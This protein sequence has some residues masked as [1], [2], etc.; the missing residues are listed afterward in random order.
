MLWKLI[1]LDALTL[2][3]NFNA[4]CTININI[5][6][7]LKATANIIMINGINRA[8]DRRESVIWDAANVEWS[9]YKYNQRAGIVLQQLPIFN[10]ESIWSS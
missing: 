3:D 10:S 4:P 8:H 2:N 1:L 9:Y 7:I 6:L 5:W